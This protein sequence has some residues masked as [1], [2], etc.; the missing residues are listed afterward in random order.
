LIGVNFILFDQNFSI[1]IEILIVEEDITEF[2]NLLKNS[3]CHCKLQIM[4]SQILI[5]GL[6]A[7]YTYTGLLFHYK[8]IIYPK[9]IRYLFPLS[10]IA[11]IVTVYLTLTVTLER[12]IAV[13]HP[14]KVRS[15]C[16]YGRAQVAVLVIVIFAFIYNLPKWVIHL[17]YFTIIF[18]QLLS[19]QTP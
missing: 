7:I 8:F 15:F 4:C 5:Y 1:H 11:Q 13:C 17:I 16:T 12:Y 10:C 18:L 14:L 2:D 6:P 19:E 3:S 9:I